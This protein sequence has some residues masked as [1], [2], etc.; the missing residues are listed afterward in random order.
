MSTSVDILINAFSEDDF[1]ECLDSAIAQ[2]G[3]GNIIIADKLN[4]PYIR[5]TAEAKNNGTIKYMNCAGQTPMQTCITLAVASDA[6]WLK[7]ICSNEILMPNC[8]ENL[9][10]SAESFE[11]ITM[12]FGALKT[13]YADGTTKTVTYDF[14]EYIGGQDYLFNIYEEI[15]FKTLSNTLVKKSVIG[16]INVRSLPDRLF[17]IHGLVSMYAMINGNLTYLNEVVAVTKQK[18]QNIN[19]IDTLSDNLEHTINPCNYAAEKMPTMKKRINE[20]KGI[21]LTEETKET[22]VVLM[23]SGRYGDAFRIIGAAAKIRLASA[24]AALFSPSVYKP[25]FKKIYHKLNI[26][27]KP[28]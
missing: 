11:N 20:L 25:L 2:N 19:D 7:Y 15:P 14:P 28:L 12:S 18:T 6:V 16:E 8:L 22:A 9:L 27:Q 10:I 21:L 23:E 4:S 13:L 26:K 1:A 5:D 17:S 24:S 3:Y